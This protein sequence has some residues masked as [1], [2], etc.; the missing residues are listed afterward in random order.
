MFETIHRPFEFDKM[1]ARSYR[2]MVFKVICLLAMPDGKNYL[3]N[4][5]FL[6]FLQR[7]IHNTLFVGWG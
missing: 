4:Y 7:A 5:S 2:D 6:F 1:S 3:E